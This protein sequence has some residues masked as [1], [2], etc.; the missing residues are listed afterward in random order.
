MDE[1]DWIAKEKQE[2]S[3]EDTT[4]KWEEDVGRRGA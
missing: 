2:V 1:A 4:D 3:V